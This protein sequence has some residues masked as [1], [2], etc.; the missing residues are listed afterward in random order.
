VKRLLWRI[1]DR[2]DDG[3]K[4][5]WRNHDGIGEHWC[6][7]DYCRCGQK[8]CKT[9]GETRPVSDGVLEVR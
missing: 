8:T 4:H 3:T 9:C 5:A 1:L 2:H 7:W 6:E